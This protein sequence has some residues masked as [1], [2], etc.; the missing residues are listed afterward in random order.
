MG[1]YGDFAATTV[2][3]LGG[4]LVQETSNPREFSTLSGWR[5]TGYGP[6]PYSPITRRPPLTWPDG[7]QVA[8]WV[9]PNIE[10][11][12][13]MEKVPAGSGGPGTPVP[14]IPSWSARDYGNR[15][16]VF[17]LM[18][19]L[20]RYGI[21]G[22]VALNSDLCAH[23]PEIIAEGRARGWEWM[24]HCESNTRRLNEAPASEEA[25]IIQRALAT[26]AEATGVRPAGWL[27]SG[28]QETWNT[29]DL[30][31]EEGCEYVCDWTNDDQPYVM[32]LDGGRR[33][34]SV[35]YSHGAKAPLSARVRTFS[36]TAIAL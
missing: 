1:K 13:L 12:S 11:F 14:D 18:R 9:I 16:G 35:P 22:T 36:T 3:R 4:R 29:L 19:V 31:A 5:A 28:L 30:L 33:L 17:R 8:L 25:G 6:F 27:G 20:D 32:S 23:H 2:T 15:V 26:I 21:R 7:A 34:V 24:G 10:F